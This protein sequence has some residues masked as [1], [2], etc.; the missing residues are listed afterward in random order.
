MNDVAISPIPKS[1]RYRS[2]LSAV[3]LIV[4]ALLVLA[5]RDGGVGSGRGASALSAGQP[6][7]AVALSIHP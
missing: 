2:L 4:L 5:A 6:V 1:F 7:Q 3:L